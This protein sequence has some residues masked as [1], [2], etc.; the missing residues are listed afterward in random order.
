MFD[1]LTRAY[2]DTCRR[3]VNIEFDKTDFRSTA[4]V[5]L[6][7]SIIELTGS[8]ITLLQSGRAVGVNIILR[9]MLDAYVDLINLLADPAYLDQMRANYH[10]EW[11]KPLKAGLAGDDPLLKAFMD[12]NFLKA[13]KYHSTEDAAL[14]ARGIRPMKTLE[15]FS[16]AGMGSAYPTVYNS[17]SAETHNNIRALIARHIRVDDEV[18]EVVIFRSTDESEMAPTLYS[19]TDMYLHSGIMVH[20]QFGS[21]QVDAFEHYRAQLSKAAQR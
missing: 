2:D 6:H 13:V 16:K 4:I 12:E 5:A 17:L 9:S 8:A 21:N 18:M 20:A 3:I 19:L 11:L 14:K 7:A 1:L 10:A 15:R